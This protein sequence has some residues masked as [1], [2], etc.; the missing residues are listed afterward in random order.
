M[1]PR[2]FLGLLEAARLHAERFRVGGVVVGGLC[3]FYNF[4][5]LCLPSGQSYLESRVKLVQVNI[6]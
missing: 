5:F 4:G 3:G 6:G 2:M 1:I